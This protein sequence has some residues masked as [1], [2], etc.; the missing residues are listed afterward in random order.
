MMVITAIVQF[1]SLYSNYLNLTNAVR[2]GAR[3]AAV[4]R[5]AA[6]PT[7]DAVSAVVNAASGLN[8]PANQVQVTS[9][10]QAGGTVTVS[11]NY[12]YTLSIFGIAVKSGSLTSTTTERVE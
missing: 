10:W 12:S 8:L 9:T 1:G 5:Q 4:S 11:A 7:G 2:S 3:V 6:N